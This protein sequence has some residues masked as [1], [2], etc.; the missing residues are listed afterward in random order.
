MR[1]RRFAVLAAAGALL[2]GATAL[3]PSAGTAS[4]EGIGPSEAVDWA[5]EFAEDAYEIFEA[6]ED[7]KANKE[8]G[9]PCSQSTATTVDEIYSTLNNFISTYNVDQGQTE[10]ALS[11]IITEL[12]ESTLTNRWT[13]ISPDLTKA[14]RMFTILTSWVTCSKA[15][16]DA[17]AGSTATC[18]ASDINGVIT[19]KPATAQLLDSLSQELVAVDTA[20]PGT[21]AV[22]WQY[23][24]QTLLPFISGSVSN[25]YDANDTSLLHAIVAAKQSAEV[26]KQDLTPGSQLRFY[27]AS[28]VN[29]VGDAVAYAI[30]LESMYMVSRIA[31]FSIEAQQSTDPNTQQYLNSDAADLQAQMTGKNADGSPAALVAPTTQNQLAA[32]TFPGWTPSTPLGASEG[33]FTGP[34]TAPVLLTNLGN[35]TSS[36]SV[37]SAAPTATEIQNI[38]TDFGSNPNQGRQSSEAGGP[39]VFLSK[40]YPATLPIRTDA[41]IPGDTSVGR[42]WSVPQTTWKT[43][44]TNATAP[45][46]YVGSGA[47]NLDSS[48][49]PVTVLG[50]DFSIWGHPL[51]GSELAHASQLQQT[52]IAYNIYSRATDTQ[53]DAGWMGNSGGASPLQLLGTPFASLL[54]VDPQNAPDSF[55][56]PIYAGDSRLV[57]PTTK[58][59]VGYVAPVWDTYGT[60]GG[61][62]GAVSSTFGAGLLVRTEGVEAANVKVQPI[63]PAGAL[64]SAASTTNN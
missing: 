22:P 50:T 24:Y 20:A 12:Q 14:Q 17:P 51:T 29:G 35:T 18:Q 26:S 59:P 1:T 45:V 30:N 25:P 5:G 42:W 15:F 61:G 10:Q 6:V 4:A 54:S 13:T 3:G 33:Y 41:T 28:Y 9:L 48:P 32:Y 43:V 2:V 21:Q 53:G 63:Q 60:A 52:P 27:S 34:N 58:Y 11:A 56:G 16:A 36:P 57:A 31:A 23:D 37:G 19:Q 44:E 49:Q 40:L 8:N 47:E 46:R 38:A 7:C 62:F 64:Q 55:G 39:Y